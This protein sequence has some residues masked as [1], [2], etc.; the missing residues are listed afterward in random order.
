M[1]QINFFLGTKLNKTKLTEIWKYWKWKKKPLNFTLFL[2]S[3]TMYS[4]PHWTLK[5][6]FE[7]IS[8]IKEHLS[9]GLYNVRLMPPSG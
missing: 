2:N 7:M 6:N 3:L 8:S 4:L 9:L 1:K 5:V